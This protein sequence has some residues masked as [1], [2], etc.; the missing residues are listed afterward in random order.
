MAP[1]DQNLVALSYL[2]LSA[3]SPD[4]RAGASYFWNNYQRHDVERIRVSQK[5]FGNV[6]RARMLAAQDW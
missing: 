2:V 1:L 5:D 3:S 4:H 6:D